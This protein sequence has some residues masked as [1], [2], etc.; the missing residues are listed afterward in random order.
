MTALELIRERRDE[1]LRLAASRGAGNVRVFG[2]AAR[3][4]DAPSS[5]IDFLVTMEPG[6]SLLDKAGLLVDL[7][8]LLGREVD[9]VADDAIYW[10]LRRRILKEAR[11]V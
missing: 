4:E 2:S 7:K 6:S 3:G 10:L 11:P 8:E 5:D 9:V 1:I